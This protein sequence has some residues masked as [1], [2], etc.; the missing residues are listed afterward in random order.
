M[1]ERGVAPPVNG[2]LHRRKVGGR[3]A[4]HQI[5]DAP[6]GYPLEKKVFTSRWVSLNSKLFADNNP[7]N[8]LDKRI[9]YNN[10]SVRKG[11]KMGQF[12]QMSA[13]MRFF[14]SRL[15]PVPFI[16]IG[17]C[18]LFFGVR[19]LYRASESTTWPVVDGTIQNSAVEYHSGSEGGGTYHAEV[20]YQFTIDGQTR[21][22]NKVAFGDYGSSNP[23]HA[24][25][26]VNRYPKGKQVSV[27]YR[28]GDPETC[29]LEPGLQGQAWFMPGFG[30]VFLV[31]GSWM[32]IFMPKLMKRSE[33]VTEQPPG[34]P[35]G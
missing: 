35:L 4:V 7:G 31:V 22:G 17:A 9:G 16:L 13:G 10:C 24:Q 15:F 21:S 33:M 2:C 26:I 29:I 23:S 3:Q 27:R 19:G 5:A 20:L 25:N 30:L 11:D 14:F 8:N 28:P 12:N 1:R 18:T 34:K 6:V 32:A